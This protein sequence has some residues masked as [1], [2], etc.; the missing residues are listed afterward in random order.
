M[1]L[2]GAEI[3]EYDS[4]LIGTGYLFTSTYLEDDDDDLDLVINSIKMNP[5]KYEIHMLYRAGVCALKL[6]EYTSK[7]Q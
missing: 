4:V 2:T 5:C 1:K 7:K 3:F 6:I